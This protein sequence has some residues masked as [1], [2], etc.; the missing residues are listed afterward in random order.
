MGGGRLAVRP[1]TAEMVLALCGRSW[2]LM[3]AL[4]DKS[5]SLPLSQTGLIDRAHATIESALLEPA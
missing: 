2:A 4:V 3:S 5:L 1:A